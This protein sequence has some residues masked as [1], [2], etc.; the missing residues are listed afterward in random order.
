LFSLNR[1]F[2]SWREVGAKT[3][4]SDIYSLMRPFVVVMRQPFLVDMIQAK[5]NEVV[6]N[7]F[8]IDTN[9][10][11]G[12]SICLGSAG[13]VFRRSSKAKGEF[14][15]SVANKMARLVVQ[16]GRPN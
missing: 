10:G 12:I 16:P 14:C 15:I 11:L 9:R 7:L 13:E 6:K 1:A 5:I 2:V 8:F 4:V 3:L